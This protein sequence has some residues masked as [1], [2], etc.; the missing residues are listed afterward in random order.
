MEQKLCLSSTGTTQ[1]ALN[2]VYDIIIWHI[3][4]AV[5]VLVHRYGPCYLCSLMFTVYQYNDLHQLGNKQSD[6]KL[7]LKA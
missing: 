6:I 1:V 3:D 7:V 2:A 4:F 5:D